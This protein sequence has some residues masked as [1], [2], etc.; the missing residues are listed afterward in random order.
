MISRL[1]K[2]K[3]LPHRLHERCSGHASSRWESSGQN[4][5]GSS[6]TDS[7][8]VCMVRELSAGQSACVAARLGHP[9]KHFVEGAPLLRRLDLPG[10]APEVEDAAPMDRPIDEL[11]S[12]LDPPG[13]SGGDDEGAE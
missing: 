5:P 7:M 2:G 1:W 12:R 11:R 10:V 4:S 8:D 6:A 9:G 13:L 3:H